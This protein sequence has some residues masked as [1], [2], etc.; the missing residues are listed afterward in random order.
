MKAESLKEVL[1]TTKAQRAYERKSNAD[2][3]AAQEKYFKQCEDEK[4]AVRVARRI[5]ANGDLDH[6]GSF[7]KFSS[8]LAQG[9]A[10][11]KGEKSATPDSNRKV[12]EKQVAEAA[13]TV[14]TQQKFESVKTADVA[15]RDAAN[16]SDTFNEK[17]R[18]TAGRVAMERGGPP[19]RYGGG[20]RK[21]EKAAK[22]DD[23]EEKK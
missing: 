2:V 15:K 8:S 19:P 16:V 23:K 18:V 5:Q 4:N 11:P 20:H 12:F 9:D 13:T 1:A 10:E 22:G 17:A 3:A 7:G 6:R 21:P 14:A